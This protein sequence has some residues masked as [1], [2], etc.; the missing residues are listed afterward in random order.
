M[1]IAHVVTMGFGNGTLV[2][3]IPDVTMMGYDVGP[4]VG[5]GGKL[6]DWQYE[7][8]IDR[9]RRERDAEE[10]RQR[11][12]TGDAV[13]AFAPVLIARGFVIHRVTVDQ[14]VVLRV[15]VGGIVAEVVRVKKG[16]GAFQAVAVAE[17]IAEG[18]NVLNAR[19][20]LASPAFGMKGKGRAIW[21][22]AAEEAILLAPYLPQALL[23]EIFTDEDED[24]KLDA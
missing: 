19:A 1:A 7:M 10:T 16:R 17:F 22:H 20:G 5:G 15:P 24:S 6:M 23:H 4:A 8:L 13:L 9:A 14:P 11:E 18:V 2:G 12:L 3:N 21:P